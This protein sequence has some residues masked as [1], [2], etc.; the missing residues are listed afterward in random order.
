MRHLY[1]DT[2]FSYIAQPYLLS[3]LVCPTACECS[4]SETLHASTV[5]EHGATGSYIDPFLPELK[6]RCLVSSRILQ[7]PAT[8]CNNMAATAELTH[9]MDI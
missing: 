4:I 3:T 7:S 5:R 1:R 8:E 2:V 6:L 9:P